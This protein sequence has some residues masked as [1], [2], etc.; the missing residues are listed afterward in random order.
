MYTVF[1]KP[2]PSRIAAILPDR[3]LLFSGYCFLYGC[4]LQMTIS[5]IDMRYNGSQITGVLNLPECFN[6]SNTTD[7][8][9]LNIH[10][11]TLYIR[12]MMHSSLEHK[13]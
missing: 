5:S 9:T 10:E 12:T 2:Y 4:F 13:A 11:G 6:S 1:S 8:L 7:P 3:G